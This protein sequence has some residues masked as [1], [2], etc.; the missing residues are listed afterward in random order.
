MIVVLALAGFACLACG[1]YRQA[2]LLFGARA[3]RRMRQAW[4]AG[5]Y[6]LLGGSLIAALATPDW[7]RGLVGWFGTLTIAALGV[8]GAG[9]T[10]SPRR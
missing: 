10:L 5:G 3:T 7:R 9:W 8:V 6:A 2:Q 4:L 1:T